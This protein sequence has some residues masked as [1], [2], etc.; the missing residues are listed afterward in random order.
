MAPE[1]SASEASGAGDEGSAGG[2][3]LIAQGELDALIAAFEAKE[4]RARAHKLSS[5]SATSSSRRFDETGQDAAG[6]AIADAA[7][8]AASSEPASGME[9]SSGGADTGPAEDAGGALSQSDIEALI[10]QAVQE[11]EPDELIDV[12]ADAEGKDWESPVEVAGE[13]E[14]SGGAT[15][16]EPAEVAME[17]ADDDS[18]ELDLESAFED[19][20]QA[21]SV[22]D[23]GDEAGAEADIE[24]TLAEVAS[25]AE[26]DAEPAGNPDVDDL[27]AVLSGEPDAVPEQSVEDADMALSGMNPEE[28]LAHQ[29]MEEVLAEVPDAAAEPVEDVGEADDPGGAETRG[30]TPAPPV[31][32]TVTDTTVIEEIGS[33]NVAAGAVDESAGMF[34]GEPKAA[35]GAAPSAEASSVDAG[36]PPAAEPAGEPSA[37]LRRSVLD[38]AR[39]EPIRALAGLAAGLLVALAAFTFLYT[40]RLRPA[41]EANLSPEG[42]GVL[43]SAVASATNLIDD[44]AYADAAELLDK[45]LEGAPE[46]AEHYDDARYLRVEAMYRALPAHLSAARANRVH[47]AIDDLLVTARTHPRAGEALLWKADVYERE[48]NPVAARAEYRDILDNFGNASV[49]DSVLARLAAVELETERPLQAITY[50]QELIQTFPNSPEVGRARLMLGDAYAAA[51][52]AENA[53]VVYIRLAEASMDSALG[54]EAFARLGKLA[55]ANGQPDA[56]IRELESRLDS[57]TTVEGNDRIYLI[58]AQAYRA[59]GEP[60]KARNILNE[61]IEFFPESDVT[62]MALV[63]LSRVL[64]ELGLQS[65]AVRMAGRAADRYPDN[66]DVLKNA[67]ALLA[68]TNDTRAA[69]QTMMAAYKAGAEQPDILLSAGD[70]LLESGA[71]EGAQAAYEQLVIDFPTSSEAVEANIGW[72]QAVREMGDLDAAYRRLSDL[73]RALEGRPKQLPVLQALGSLY[74]DLGLRQEMI[75]TYGRVAGITSDPAALADAARSLMQA[76]AVDE[77]LMIASRVDPAKLAPAEAYAFLMAQGKVILRRDANQALAMMKH[78]HEEYADQRTADGV[79]TLLNAALGAG[80]SAY[81]RGVV[82]DLQARVNDGTHA[83]ERPIFEEAASA[84]GDYLYG[85]GDFEAASAAYGIALGGAPELGEAPVLPENPSSLGPVQIW[86]AYQRAN[87]LAALDRYDESL[88]LYRLVAQSG[89]SW[90]DE[91]KALADNA[92]L[93]QRLR[94]EFVP[95]AGGTG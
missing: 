67:G 15:E 49:R 22:D 10:A 30:E 8:S 47:A 65:E 70:Y 90:A 77:G 93:E 64:D 84:Y 71:Y 1:D 80:K 60:E 68:E 34:A 5:A 52:D 41:D 40:H 48:G 21:A 91:A 9:G 38:V 85:R 18:G 7:G 13:S 35:S 59:A 53:R 32:S 50:L 54:A 86:S 73:A 43:G 14:L 36:E 55:L 58:L 56:A 26:E 74:G 31:T 17:A 57:A 46:T 94:G 78:A 63:E 4:Q 2:S 95:Q 61:L 92:A 23:S 25:A 89:S 83:A 6:D 19:L 51:G 88:P 76:G 12:A 33:E 44:G 45:A 72:A 62:P 69:G 66:A 24:E 28:S 29:D 87:A 3:G 81:A 42:R 82:S 16:D 27:D 79:L 11:T 20:T 75:E 37:W 39:Q